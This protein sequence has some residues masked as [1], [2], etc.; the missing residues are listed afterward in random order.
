MRTL[1]IG[2]SRGS[3]FILAAGVDDA[4]IISL[5]VSF[6]PSSGHRFT[7]STQLLVIWLI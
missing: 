7:T 5:V 1:S 4:H 2:L 6:R 3:N